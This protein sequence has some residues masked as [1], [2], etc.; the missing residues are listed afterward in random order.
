MPAGMGEEAE[1]KAADIYSKVM[2]ALYGQP[3]QSEAERL[4]GGDTCKTARAHDH[5]KE[6]TWHR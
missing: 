3:P 6:K 1:A 4:T 2:A 5:R